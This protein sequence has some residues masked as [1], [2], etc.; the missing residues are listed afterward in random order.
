MVA[1]DV[2]DQRGVDVGEATA[3]ELLGPGHPDPAGLAERA[4]DLARVAV[5]EH[6]LT[7]PLR[8]GL[9]LRAER[10]RE[11]RRF[12]AQR[13]LPVGQPEIHPRAI[14]EAS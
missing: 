6:P 12:L 4:R 5:G 1:E 14:V 7:A 2:L 8:I 9:Q 10:G 3:A 11:R 13:D